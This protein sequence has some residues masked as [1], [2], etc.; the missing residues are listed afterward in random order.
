MNPTAII[1]AAAAAGIVLQ[2]SDGKLR[3]TAARKPAD[4]LMERIRTAKPAIITHLKSVEAERQAP[5]SPTPAE[6]VDD[7]LR[8]R[9]PVP[10]D[11]AGMPVFDTADDHLL[12]T[13]IV[14][15]AICN[16]RQATKEALERARMA[17]DPALA[18]DPAEVGLR[19]EGDPDAPGL[20]A[21]AAAMTP[22]GDAQTGHHHEHRRPR[23]G[24]QI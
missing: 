3:L 8:Y 5:A 17:V 7:A 23:T 1:E 2:M 6:V 24:L 14:A 10:T 19:G 21:R 22:K 18:D 16:Q 4:E 20:N 13:G 15:S 9:S 11:A 12:G